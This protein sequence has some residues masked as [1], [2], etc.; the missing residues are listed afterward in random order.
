MVSVQLALKLPKAVISADRGLSFHFILQ[1]LWTILHFTRRKAIFCSSST[2]KALPITS[3]GLLCS[4][5][6]QKSMT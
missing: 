1:W 2:W 6:K 5:S 4:I 3:L